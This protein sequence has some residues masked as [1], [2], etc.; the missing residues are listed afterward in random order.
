MGD[1]EMGESKRGELVKKRPVIQL[2]IFTTS[3]AKATQPPTPVL[4]RQA[5]VDQ[6]LNVNATRGCRRCCQHSYR[7]WRAG[8]RQVSW[9]IDISMSL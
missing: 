8:R 9:M 7:L 6:R 4:A 5:T 1:G 2:F 3:S